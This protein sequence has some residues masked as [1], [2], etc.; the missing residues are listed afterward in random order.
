MEIEL[1]KEYDLANMEIAKNKVLDKL[2]ELKHFVWMAVHPINL[3]RYYIVTGNDPKTREVF[4]IMIM[5]KREIFF[6]FGEM[7]KNQGAKGSGDSINVKDLQI[8]IQHNVKTIYI[9]F[10]NSNVYYILLQEFLNKSIPW[11]NREGKKVRSISL[12]EYKRLEE[13][14]ELQEP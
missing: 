14:R 5:F 6:S 4:D 12:S 13:T 11:T 2:K 1:T 8:A 3:G 10:S 9:I 7:F